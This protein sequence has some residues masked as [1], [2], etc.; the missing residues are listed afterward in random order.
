MTFFLNSQLGLSRSLRSNENRGRIFEAATSKF[1]NHSWHFFSSPQN[2]KVDL[3]MTNGSKVLIYLTLLHFLLHYLQEYSKIFQSIFFSWNQNY[4][5][6]R[7][8]CQSLTLIP[9]LTKYSKSHVVIPGYAQKQQQQ[10]ILLAPI[11]QGRKSF[12]PKRLCTV[13]NYQYIDGIAYL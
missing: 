10:N 6:I 1:C 5:A 2:G 7:N 11:S 9:S 13:G 8:F 3:C 12:W 4:L